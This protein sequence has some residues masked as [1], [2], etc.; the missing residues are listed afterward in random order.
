M[1]L[2]TPFWQA[3]GLEG[4]NKKYT[5]ICHGH[6]WIIPTYASNIEMV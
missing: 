2:A 1:F 6:S 5:I 4:I 3:I